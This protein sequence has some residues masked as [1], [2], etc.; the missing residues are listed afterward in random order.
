MIEF[1]RTDDSVKRLEG[2]NE[3]SII[4]CR[5]AGICNLN[6]SNPEVVN[7]W[8]NRKLCTSHEDVNIMLFYVYKYKNLGT[9]FT[10]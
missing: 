3:L 1:M 10:P 8:K 4:L 6:F 2:Q 5:G 9:F 7:E